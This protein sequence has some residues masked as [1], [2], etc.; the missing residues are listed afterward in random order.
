MQKR[1]RR[2]RRWEPFGD[3]RTCK[4]CDPPQPM[5]YIESTIE[6]DDWIQK[7]YYYCEAGHVKIVIRD[8]M[9][10]FGPRDEP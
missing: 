9:H 2:V 5:R 3:T 10:E 6:D 7:D 8:D 4:K 1:V